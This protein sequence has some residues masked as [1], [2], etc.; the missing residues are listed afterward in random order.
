M[1]QTNS[2]PGSTETLGFRILDTLSSSIL[3]LDRKCRIS[4][5]NAAGEALFESSAASIIGRRFD[6]LLSQV[7]PSNILDRLT[8]DSIA[9][10]EHEAVITLANGKSM[11]A[12]YSIYPFD[13]QTVD[14][15]FLL[16]I[17]PLERQAQFAQDELNQLQQ[18]ASH[19]LARGLA[20]EINNPLGGIRGAAQLL[21]RALD[22]P[23]WT[24]YTEVII[25]EVDR[26]QS[27]TSNML[28][29][30]SALQRK[31]VNILEV[32]EH[33]RKIIHAAEPDRIKI[34]R[35]YDPSIPE[36]FADRDM[37]IQAFLNIARNAVQAIE[38]IGQ[39]VFKT[40]VD[41]QFTIGRV[42]HPLVVQID[43]TDSGCGIPHE[44]GETIFLPMIT[45]KPEGSGLGLPMAQEIIS[46]HGGTLQ[47]HSSDSGTTFSII[48]PLEIS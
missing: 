24:E 1:P 21:Q 37:L 28:G 42:T 12:N 16:E 34:S 46:R 32:L 44:L 15:E 20:H 41:R 23:E 30:E 22:R 43:I 8:L 9:F 3:C 48:L 36:L 47:L 29:P 31:Q 45:D 38:G 19:Q 2:T 40:R 26:L 5:I 27:L 10:T 11:I 17:Q 4:Y 35:D 33:I 39:I 13:E 18:Q 7:E 25:S 14:G 6:S